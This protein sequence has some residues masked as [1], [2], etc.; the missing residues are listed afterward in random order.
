MKFWDFLKENNGQLSSSRLFAFLVT[1]A[2]IIDWMHSVFAT[3]EGV[4]RPEW[5]TIMMVLG[6]L[7]FKVAQKFTENK[8]SKPVAPDGADTSAP[9]PSPAAA[10]P[11]SKAAAAKAAAMAEDSLPKPPVE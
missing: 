5:S 10:K 7:G 6:V 8:D 11:P 1:I 9:T 2:T 4:W 3:P